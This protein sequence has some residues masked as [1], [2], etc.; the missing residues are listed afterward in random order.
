MIYQSISRSHDTHNTN[1]LYKQHGRSIGGDAQAA[2]KVRHAIRPLAPRYV[3]HV[4]HGLEVD[5]NVQQFTDQPR[6][7]ERQHRERRRTI[8][9]AHI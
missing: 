4:G 5:E 1:W 7:D 8:L 6:T 2:A 3:S 9:N